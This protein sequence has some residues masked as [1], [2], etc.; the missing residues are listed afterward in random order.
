MSNFVIDKDALKKAW[1]ADSQYW[2]S[3]VDYKIVEDIDFLK[4]SLSDGM[5]D[6]EIFKLDEFIPYF[7]FKRSEL[8]KAYVQTITNTKIKSKFEILDDDAVVEYFW[9]CFHVYPDLFK[10]VEEFQSEYILG[11]LEN[12]CEKNKINYTVEL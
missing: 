5:D 10:D 2:F 6:D 4:L 3:L 12:W 11:R 7:H 9:K 1:G 8:A